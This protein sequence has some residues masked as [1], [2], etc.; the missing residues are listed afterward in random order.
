MIAAPETL[1]TESV[2]GRKTTRDLFNNPLGKCENIIS[3]LTLV[4]RPD[5]PDLLSEAAAARDSLLKPFE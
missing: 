3:N 4:E 2:D 5:R 1:F